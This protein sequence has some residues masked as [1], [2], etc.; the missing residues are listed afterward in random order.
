MFLRAIISFLSTGR[1]PGSAVSTAPDFTSTAQRVD[2]VL[3]K[4]SPSREFTYLDTEEQPDV[5]VTANVE[6]FD[7]TPSNPENPGEHEDSDGP[8]AG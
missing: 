3:P 5:E 4:E 2:A 7:G 1:Q 6:S 8:V